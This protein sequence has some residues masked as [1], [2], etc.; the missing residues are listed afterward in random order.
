MSVVA[1][2]LSVLGVVLLVPVL[3]VALQI[4]VALPARRPRPAPEGPR[5]RLA[6]LVPAHDE[7][8]GIAATVAA[9]RAQLAPGDRLLVV[10]D[11][12]CDDT[13]GLAWRA[14]AQVLVRRDPERRGKGHALD[15]G[16]R[17]LEGRPPE[18]VAVVDADCRPEAG[19]LERLARTCARTRRPVQALYR[20]QAP[21]GAGLKTRLAAFASAVKNE[22][23]PRG[24]LRL[25][26]PCQLMG[27]G[28]AFPWATL[29]DVPLASSHLVE[30]LK[31][32]LDLARLGQPPLFVPEAVVGSHFPRS[33][34]GLRTQRTRWEHGHLGM[35]L[36]EAPRLLASAL[37]RR[38]GPLLALILDLLVPPLALLAL[39]LAALL[40]AA[41]LVFA[42]GG[43]GLPLALAAAAWGLLTTAVFLAWGACGR[44]LVSLAELLRAPLYALAKLPLYRDFLGR[45]QGDWVR[46]RRDAP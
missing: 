33:A 26:L 37:V 17:H 34:E 21:A 16:V 29:R 12:C 13:A 10:A 14:G 27:S 2:A 31:L 36:E 40:A 32:G 5:P 39:G 30:D 9:I 20:I 25:G 23:R 18:V 8:L 46:S 44:P 42:V 41:G 4:L 7:A 1:W 43:P 24:W 11:N 45:R 19:A 38:N 28:M 22:L 6:V 3:V 35:I 15:F